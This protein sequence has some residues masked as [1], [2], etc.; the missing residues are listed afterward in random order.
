MEREQA[1]LEAR[2]EAHLEQWMA[3]YTAENAPEQVKAII[4][5]EDDSRT[6]VL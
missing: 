3:S 6:L 1:T 4:A 2:S 5:A